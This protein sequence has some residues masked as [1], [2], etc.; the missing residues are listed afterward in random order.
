MDFNGNFEYSQVVN[1]GFTLPL[2]FSLE[3]N[4]PNPFNP[5][6]SIAFSVPE[7]SD[8]T[9]DVYNLIGQKLVTL[10]QGV[11]ESGKHTAQLNAST[12]SSGVY[13][14]KLTAIGENGSQFTS[15]KKMTLL[16]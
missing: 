6:T 10:I 14:F 16:K 3:Q 13:I 11:V 9:L 12:M 1:L 4:Y 7:K 8:V 5:S 15:S 2:D